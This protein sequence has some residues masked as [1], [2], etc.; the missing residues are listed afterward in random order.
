MG[1]SM[2]NSNLKKYV[3]DF[4][5]M[6]ELYDDNKGHRYKELLEASIFNFLEN[7]ND[8]NA[9]EV[10][11]TFFMIYQITSED[12]SEFNV[13]DGAMS[14]EHN[15]LL[16]LVKIM[17]KY[18][19]YTGELIKKQ[20]DH[21]IHSV[22][23]FLLGLAIYSQ[24]NEYRS[25]FKRYVQRSKYKNYYKIRKKYFSHEEFLYRWGI[26]SLF[27]DIGY[28]VEIIGRQMEKFINDGV[29]SISFSY[30]VTTA[31]EFRDFNEFNTIRRINYDF[32]D[33]FVKAYPDAKFLDLFKPTDLMAFKIS[34]DL[35]DVDVNDLKK[36]LNRFID[37]M[38]ENGFID[39]GF[40]SSILVLN[41]YGYLIQKYSKNFNFFFYPIVDSATAILLHNYYRN[42]LMDKEGEFK[43]GSL[44]PNKSP[45]AFL[46]ILCD[47]LQ[48]W[49]RRPVGSED[50][51][52]SHVNQ[53]EIEITD[54]NLDLNYIVKSG[55]LGLGFSEKKEEVLK[56][57]LDLYFLFPLGLHIK[58]DVKYVSII[59]EME[60]ED[61][62][63]P[64]VLF[65]NV[66]ILARK[67]HEEYVLD[68]E[69]EGKTVERDFSKLSP[70]IKMSNV[71]QAK[72][73]AKKLSLVG[74]EMAPL[75]D[76]REVYE[77]S[78]D[79]IV[80][81]SIMEHEE[82]CEHKIQNGWVYGD[83]RDDDNKIHPDIAEWVDMRYVSSEEAEKIVPRLADDRK[84]LDVNTVKNIPLLL[85]SIGMKVVMSKLRALT[86]RKHEFYRETKKD[87]EEFDDLPFYVKF[88]NFRQTD[89]LIKSLGELKL[90]LVSIDDP[91]SEIEKL[92][93]NQIEYLAKRDHA[94]W[95]NSKLNLGWHYGDEKTAETNPNL[96]EWD[97]L[98]EDVQILN[99]K[100]FEV[101]P[102]LCREVGLKIVEN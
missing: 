56:D 100:T 88:L 96:V 12:K 67:I 87:V 50:K 4:F 14:N 27:H 79:E 23:V 54:F 53:L 65:R 33:D 49:N 77:F 74:C 101:L 3:S 19:K 18:E 75:D 73:I 97:D 42:V 83:P 55:A 48:E 63:A 99:K 60:K 80:D 28:P 45:L 62:Q 15:T 29:K 92:T 71:R 85:E 38:G 9:Y 69:K 84:M 30:D 37:I 22:N 17:K 16:D 21:F 1:V 82:W 58:T 94:E 86:I 10:F 57:V 70:E 24:N 76:P 98:K 43:L 66:E 36:H 59:K 41:S 91:A 78:A 39:H 26:A 68:Q 32:A 51:K 20:R 11:E 31:I 52:K 7:E 102:R 5:N 47:E 95:Y 72:S 46:L 6:V 35:P 40:F 90:D 81:L 2:E 8:G 93:D 13:S 44:S 34:K 25:L 61:L 64:S 89:V